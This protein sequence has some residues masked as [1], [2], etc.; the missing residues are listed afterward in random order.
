M[1]LKWRVYCEHWISHIVDLQLRITRLTGNIIQIKCSKSINTFRNECIWLVCVPQNDIF[2]ISFR[3]FSHT[4]TPNH[5]TMACTL[6]GRN[7][8][9]ESNAK[10]ILIQFVTSQ[11]T[12]NHQRIENE[13]NTL[14]NVA[15]VAV[16]I[17]DKDFFTV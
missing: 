10:E 4:F 2:N 15:C 14:L 3:K 1:D 6:S 8:Y 7:A 16:Q 5:E 17:N 12:S 11:C 13:P 9:S